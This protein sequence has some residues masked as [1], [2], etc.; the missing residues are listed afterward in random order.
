MHTIYEYNLF[1]RTYV[2]PSPKQKEKSGLLTRPMSSIHGHTPRILPFR[3]LIYR[4]SMLDS[5]LKALLIPIWTLIRQKLMPGMVFWWMD[6][7]GRVKRPDFWFK[8]LTSF[9]FSE[10]EPR[11]EASVAEVMLRFICS[12]S[13]MS[14]EGTK[15]HGTAYDIIIFYL[16][17]R[18][19]HCIFVSFFQNRIASHR[20]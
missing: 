5:V 20:S 13:L 18:F 12:H 8:K 15:K 4:K 9:W 14:F 3:V 19:R 17:H 2:S 16:I 7:I 11:Q 10:M 6:D 1:K